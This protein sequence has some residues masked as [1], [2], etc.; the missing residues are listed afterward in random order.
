MAC[1]VSSLRRPRL[2]DTLGTRLNGC[3]LF[4]GDGTQEKEE[5]LTTLGFNPPEYSNSLHRRFFCVF[6][7]AWRENKAREKRG[8]D[9]GRCRQFH[10]SKIA[11][12]F[13]V[14]QYKS[15]PGWQKSKKSWHSPRIRNGR[16]GGVVGLK[17]YYHVFAWDRLWLRVGKA[18]CRGR[19][20]RIKTAFSRITQNSAFDCRPYSIA[21]LRC[22]L[23]WSMHR[24]EIIVFTP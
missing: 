12:E 15:E 4:Y 23:F 5:T 20:T 19:F 7:P 13:L 10:T 14:I 21:K 11:C 16:R 9:G 1:L 6:R 8:K 17:L 2:E 18:G 22:R 3:F 24:Q